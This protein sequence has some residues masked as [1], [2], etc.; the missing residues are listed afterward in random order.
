MAASFSVLRRRF[1]PER[2]FLGRILFALIGSM[3]AVM[4]LPF[5]PNLK[6]LLIVMTCFIGVFSAILYGTFYQ[7]V[8]LLRDEGGKVNAY[9]SMGY[10][11]AGLFILVFSLISGFQGHQMHPTLL[12]RVILAGL[13]MLVMAASLFVFVYMTVWS[14]NYHRA[15][16]TCVLSLLFFSLGLFIAFSLRLV[17]LTSRV[18]RHVLFVLGCSV[19]FFSPSPTASA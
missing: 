3:V 5:L 6:G 1:N 17:A 4:M 12:Q 7:L 14:G 10:Q 8:S 2:T 15:I 13:V 11:G 9:F 18:Q 19:I 16:H